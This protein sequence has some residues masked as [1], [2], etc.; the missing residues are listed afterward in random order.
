[1]VGQP[2]IGMSLAGARTAL[3]A[4]PAA[5][6]ALIAGG[7]LLRRPPGRRPPHAQRGPRPRARRRL[8]LR[9]P[10]PARPAVGDRGLGAR[11]LDRVLPSHG[12]R[13]GARHRLARRGLVGRVPRARR[14]AG[15]RWRGPPGHV[16][17]RLAARVAH[18][19]HRVVGRPLRG[20]GGDQVLVRGGGS[21]LS[22]GYGPGLGA[23]RASRGFRLRGRGA[24]RCRRRPQRPRRAHDHRRRR[25]PRHPPALLGRRGRPQLPRRRPRGRHRACRRPAALRPRSDRQGRR[26]RR[27]RR[28]RPGPGRHRVAWRHDRRGGGARGRRG[29][30]ARPARPGRGVRCLCGRRHGS[31]LP[32]LPERPGARDEL[33]CG[34]QRPRGAVDCRVADVRG[35][36]PR[37]LRHRKLPV[38]VA[39]LRA[40][41]GQ[42]A[43]SSGSSSTSPMSRTTS[44]SSSSPRPGSWGSA[45]C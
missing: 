37:G 27:D 44:T 32:R 7:A 2:T 40:R 1:M 3:P 6:Q 43:I 21:L 19:V 42:P 17:P 8:R 13:A 31:V 41:A 28:P 20:V 16:R 33:R 23:H 35:P 4:R 14:L 29:P 11:G 26:R 12:A 34:G 18:A 10:R 38:R 36:P 9:D 39:Q 5:L 45:C 25:R 22:R 15:R 30:G 24:D